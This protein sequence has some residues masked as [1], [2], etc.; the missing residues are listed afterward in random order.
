MQGLW[1]GVL[2]SLVMVSNP[3]INFVLYEWL[4]ARLADLKR[5]RASALTGALGRASPTSHR[6]WCWLAMNRRLVGPVKC[7]ATYSPSPDLVGVRA[8]QGAGALCVGRT[9][10]QAA[11]LLCWGLSC[12]AAGAGSIPVALPLPTAAE[13][14]AASAVAKLGATLATYPLLL[15]KQR[16]QSAGRHTHED[17]VYSGTLDAVQRIWKTEGGPP[18]ASLLQ[19]RRAC[20]CAGSEPA[21]D[22]QGSWASS[23]A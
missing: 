19:A 10:A 20:L 2:P 7:A 17:R 16:L 15:V 12:P 11:A 14:F 3:T 4:L 21:M 6:F 13:V 23:T 22:L 5:R 9:T 18:V 8:W 1:K